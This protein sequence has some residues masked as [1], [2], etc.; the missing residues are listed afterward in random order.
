MKVAHATR[1]HST[2]CI[3]PVMR[4]RPEVHANGGPR[5]SVAAHTTQ[6]L[7]TKYARLTIPTQRTQEDNNHKATAIVHRASQTE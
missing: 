6:V 3:T 4:S 5:V 1:T 7:S 2:R